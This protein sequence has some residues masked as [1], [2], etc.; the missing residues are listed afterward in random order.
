VIAWPSV[1]A[2]LVLTILEAAAVLVSAIAG[3]IVASNKRMD[4]VGAFALACVNAFGGGTVRDLLLDNRPFYW[5]THWWLLLAIL[6]ICVAFVY[7]ARMY[8]FASEVHR[9]SVRVDAIGLALFTVAGVGIARE[10]GA[11]LVVTAIMGVITGTM[12][13]VL[14]DVVVNDIPDLFRPGGLY[15]TAS[16]AGSL[17]FIGA[18]ENELR[19]SYAAGIGIVVVVALRLASVK[20]G[21]TVPAPQW[22]E[23]PGREA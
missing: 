6:M 5:M 7:N 11:P 18:L 4:V 2:E 19:Y 15:A 21:V 10:H 14:R 23:D 16:F 8:H 17:A 20:H 9:R 13:G 1:N 3:M 22:H 12:G